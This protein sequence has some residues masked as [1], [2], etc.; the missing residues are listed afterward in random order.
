M[1]LFRYPANSTE[2]P[3]EEALGEMHRKWGAFIGNLALQEKLLSTHQLGEHGCQ[4]H[5]NGSMEQGLQMQAGIAIGGNMIVRASSLHEAAD[6]A[7]HCPI[8]LM[9]GSV[10]VRDIQPM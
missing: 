5:A 10:E 6:M 1:L 8:L 2:A 4:L 9:G 7:K 3:S